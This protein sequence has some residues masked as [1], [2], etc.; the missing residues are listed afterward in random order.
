MKW[1]Q[2]RVRKRS[3]VNGEINIKTYIKISILF[4]N[5]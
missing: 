1:S 2:E 4:R 5:G 3:G